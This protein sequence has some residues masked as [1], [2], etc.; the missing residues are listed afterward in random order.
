M[1]GDVSLTIKKRFLLTLSNDP[2]LNGE[3][4]KGLRFSLTKHVNAYYL[5]FV[6]NRNDCLHLVKKISVQFKGPIKIGLPNLLGMNQWRRFDSNCKTFQRSNPVN[7]SVKA[8]EIHVFSA[9][10]KIFLKMKE[11]N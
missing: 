4:L 7:I 9:Q 1:S 11:P 5:I 8:I 10:E 3:R 2:N 6:D